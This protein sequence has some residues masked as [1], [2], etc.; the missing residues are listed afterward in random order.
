MGLKT[1]SFIQ[2][3]SFTYGYGLYGAGSL[4]YGGTYGVYYHF[5]N[6]NKY[7]LAC[8][9]P[10]SARAGM[11]SRM[12]GVTGKGSGAEG[13]LICDPYKDL[14]FTR[15]YFE[16]SL[17]YKMGK[18]KRFYCDLMGRLPLYSADHPD[19]DG[20]GM[21]YAN[22]TFGWNFRVLKGHANKA[23]L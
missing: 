10:F 15:I 2:L 21:S 14:P 3:I 9:F 8:I 17:Y 4:T 11:T 5:G 12:A 20:F 6:F 22:L 23:K 7:A 19:S 1:T 18:H 13:C 16:P